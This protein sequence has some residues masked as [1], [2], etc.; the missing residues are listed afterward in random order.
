LDGI[1]AL[2]AAGGSLAWFFD[3]ESGST[4]RPDPGDD[5]RRYDPYHSETELGLPSGF[6]A[7]RSG[8]AHPRTPNGCGNVWSSPAYDGKRGFLYFASSN[9]DTDTDPA[10]LRP[11]P[12]MPPYDE[13][14]FALD[15][16]GAPVWRWRPREVDNGD[17]AFGAA[18]NLFTAVVGGTERDVLGIGN[19]DGTYYLLDRDGVNKVSGVRWDDADPSSLPYWRTNVVPGGPAGGVIATAA[20]DDEADRIYFGTAPGSFGSVTNPQRPTMH[21]LDAG[22]GAILWQNTAEPNADATFAPTSAIPGVVFTGTAVGGFLRAYDTATGDKLAAVPNGFALA[23]APAVV[24][25]LVLV[26]GG[27]GQR[28][29]NPANPADITSR[30]PHDLTALCVPGTP[31][32]AVDVPVAGRILRVRDRANEPTARRLTLEARDAAIAIP[33]TGSTGDPTL[34]GAVVDLLNPLSGE[35]QTIAL[36]A[37]G[38][39]SSR[40]GYRYR[41]R[42]AAFGPCARAFL[43]T[44]RWKAKCRGAG[45][46]F[47]LDE[48]VQDTLVSALALGNDRVYC[49]RFG[50]VVD[51]DAGLT[52][53]R[54]GRFTARDAPAPDT[55]P[56]P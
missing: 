43:R 17:L 46:T 21:A 28:S 23:S 31:A 16:D 38:W 1:Y 44:G 8:C 2:D 18:P 48:P 10:T 5:I 34:V 12:P 39:Q 54:S 40:D 14:V 47:T 33:A 27:I 22:T 36:P 19:K 49:T 45:I 35:R 9:C 25:G 24:D 41:D 50:G 56:L 20:V 37:S 15:L 52:A 3:L 29:D 6:L 53:S 4:C 13:A 42:L 7:T 55:C 11:L 30:L 32:C 51:T 26:G